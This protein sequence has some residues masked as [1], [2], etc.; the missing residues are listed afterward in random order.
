MPFPQPGQTLPA[1][2]LKTAET[3]QLLHLFIY[4]RC[5]ITLGGWLR[6]SG[7]WMELKETEI[8]HA[9]MPLLLLSKYCTLA[10]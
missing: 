6:L 9:T 2:N 3:R 10:S 1:I 4:E 8:L 7:V 5:F